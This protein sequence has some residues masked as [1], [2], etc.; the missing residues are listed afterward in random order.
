MNFPRTKTHKKIRIKKEIDLAVPQGWGRTS[1]VLGSAP[2]TAEKQNKYT[3]KEQ[4]QRNKED[5]N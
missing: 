2:R 5:R 4:E 1:K 3:L